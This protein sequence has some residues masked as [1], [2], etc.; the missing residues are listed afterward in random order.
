MPPG[1]NSTRDQIN[2]TVALSQAMSALTIPAREMSQEIRGVFEGDTSR[3]SRLNQVLRIT[4]AEIDQAALSGTAYQLVMGRLKAFSEG[5]ERGQRTYNVALSNLHDVL[6]QIEQTGTADLFELLKTKILELNAVLQKPETR[7]AV[8]GWGKE[9]ELFAQDA[10]AM[11]ES[12]RKDAQAIVGLI[13]K[14][15]DLDPIFLDFRDSGPGRFD[16][17]AAQ[18]FID[19]AQKRRGLLLEEISNAGTLELKAKA[20][21]ALE[22]ERLTLTD[23]LGSKNELIRDAA[24]LM[25]GLLQEI[26]PMF[27]SMAG[28]AER[29]A[30]A[31]K[32]T[33]EQIEAAIKSTGTLLEVQRQTA[34]NTAKAAGDHSGQFAAQGNDA[35]NDTFRKLYADGAGFDPVKAARE[36]EKFANSVREAAQHQQDVTDAA[37][38]TAAAHRDVTAVLRQQETTLQDVRQQQQLI[39]QNP[40]LTIDQKNAQLAVLIREEIAKL[41]EEIA[42][43][44]GLIAGGTLDPSTYE[45]V[46]QKVQQARAEVELL[47]QKTQTLNFGGGLQESLFSWVNSFGT[48]AQQIGKAITGS[49]NTALDATADALTDVIFRTGDWRQTVLQAE[50]AIVSSLI[51]I[52]L[53]MIA[54]KVLGSFLTRQSTAEQTQANVSLL[55]SATATAAAQ[56][57]ATSGF[58]WVFAGIAAAAAIALIIGLL[59]GGFEKGGYTGPGGTRQIAGVVHGR[60]FVQPKDTVDYYGLDV[61]EAMRQRRIP[62]EKI[63]AL[64]GNYRYRVTPRVG[65]FEIGG[66]VAAV[67]ESV[68]SR[69]AAAAAAPAAGEMKVSNYVL[70]DIRELRQRLLGDDAAEVW[71]TDV[72]N[73]RSHLVR[74]RA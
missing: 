63:Q 20:Q 50:K 9:L 8:R 54:Q 10:F 47:A 24:Q 27:S 4:K 18:Q 43:G 67:T 36:A 31:M 41:N 35:F 69:E 52:G 42:I 11:L 12:T 33:K 60:E 29:T 13:E 37:K 72:F 57:G 21:L 19:D 5:A 66:A 59:S 26:V 23:R 56:S 28:E 30:G 73:R 45:Q 46:F 7:E 16:K 6:V 34:I 74:R 40:F 25:L 22:N 70:T 71:V 61:H 1:I 2:L 55:P 39:N 14:L 68:E 65:S 53:Q 51:K 3:Q 48:A 62:A 15:G 58:N 17:A 44:Q 38:G 64:L 49:I 32:L